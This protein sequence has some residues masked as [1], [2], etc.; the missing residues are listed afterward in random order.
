ME[1]VVPLSPTRNPGKLYQQEAGKTPSHRTILVNFS[2]KKM[3][4]IIFT[5]LLQESR[6]KVEAGPK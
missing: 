4:L 1:R 5:V 2:C 6:V 3:L